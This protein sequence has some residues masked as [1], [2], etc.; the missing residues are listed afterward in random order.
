MSRNT[1]PAEKSSEVTRAKKGPRTF[2]VKFPIVSVVLDPN[3]EKIGTKQ[4]RKVM[5]AYFALTKYADGDARVEAFL[6]T[7]FY[8][9]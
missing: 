9:R 5:K 7:F 3:L 4:D 6:N 1:V 2:S 8:S